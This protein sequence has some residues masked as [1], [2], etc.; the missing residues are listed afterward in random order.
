MREAMPTKFGLHVFH[1]SLYL[2]EFFEPDLFFDPHRLCPWFERKIWSILKRSR[3]FET[4]EATPTK[5]G[6]HAFQ[7][8]HYLHEF[9]EPIQFFDPHGLLGPHS[10]WGP[11]FPFGLWSKREI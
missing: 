7:V 10:P 11:Y 5:I 4:G 2:Y 1:I 6:L 8:N 9:F 3:I